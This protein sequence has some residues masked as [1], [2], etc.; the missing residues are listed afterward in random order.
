MQSTDGNRPIRY[1][2]AGG[3][4]F[5]GHR[6]VARL[7]AQG[8]QV[9]VI[10]NR[11][12]YGVYDKTRHE[13]NLRAREPYLKGAEIHTV[14][15]L[16][17]DR[18]KEICTGF[19]P[20]VVVHLASIPIAG[21]AVQQP[22]V[23]SREMV[24]GT[25]SLI[26]AVRAT[27]IQRY[28]YV[29]SSM[30]YGDFLHDSIPETH[31]QQ[32]KEPYGALKLSCEFFVR[33]YTIVHGMPHVIIRPTAVYG[34]TGNDA[35]VLTRF[36][37]AARTGQKIQVLGPDTRL[38][39]TFV[40]DAALG[41]TLAATSPNALNETFNISA[42]RARSLLEAAQYLKSREPSLEME[43]GPPDPLYPR[44]GAL[45]IDKARKMLGYEPRY[46][47]ENGLDELLASL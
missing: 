40:E 17:H 27:G 10:D 26:E 16:E 32:P 14:S 21:I 37:R 19:R 46:T 12:N 18:I 34:P 24:E 42:G 39:F 35:F 2:V 23:T 4:G 8:A 20:D 36:A 28:V 43:V 3:F 45:S 1:L 25:A 38:D 29:S 33:S 22:I 11:T 31:Q 13:Q 41:V 5:I 6:V 44:R 15:I 9:V 7:H 30:T 47:L